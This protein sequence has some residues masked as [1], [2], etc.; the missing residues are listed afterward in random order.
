MKALLNE[1]LC[2]T[3]EEFSAALNFN[4]TTIGKR[5]HKFVFNQKEA[6]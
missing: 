6:N 4:T 3:L 5:L 2:Q 1:D